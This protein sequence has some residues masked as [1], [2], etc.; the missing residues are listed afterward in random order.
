MVE[1]KKFETF[2]KK[3]EPNWAGK[4]VDPEMRKMKL[5]SPETLKLMQQRE[6]EREKRRYPFTYFLVGVE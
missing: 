5:N 6:R 3:K 2:R 1:N 4:T